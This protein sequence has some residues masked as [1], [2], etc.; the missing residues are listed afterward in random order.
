MIAG[1][2]INVQKHPD[3]PLWLY[4]YSMRAQ[5]HD[6]WNE[7]TCICR[8]LIMDEAQNIVSRPFKKFFNYWQIAPEDI[9]NEPF[10]VTDKMD[11][12]LGISYWYNGI[13][14]IATRGSFNGKQATRAT[15]ILHR[16]YADCCLKMQ[17]QYTY[18]FE[19]IYPANRIIVDYGA[20]EELVLLA[21]ID[22]ETGRELP[23]FANIGFP[24]L[25]TFEGF[26]SFEEVLQLNDNRAEG[27]VV[28]FESGLRVKVKFPEYLRLHR[29]MLG[30]SETKIW[31][32][33][34]NKHGI[35]KL[36]EKA[37]EEY[38]PWI[39]TT[40]AK[41]T[42]SYNVLYQKIM[43]E[44]HALPDFSSQKEAAEYI[45]NSPNETLLF[46]LLHKKPID[47]LVWQRIK[48]DENAS[49]FSIRG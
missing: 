12:S 20:R 29:I 18:L 9:P 19:I 39:R 35:E 22:T 7:A 15:Q 10:V 44:F 47:K 4:N 43:D 32:Y 3:F 49:W 21:V 2:F 6:V 13:W 37:G 45:K 33:L 30:L 36:C 24:I 11:G 38:S 14:S 23:D 1:R 46:C 5:S 28:R 16:K 34:A 8:G 26:N 41:L 25:K 42:S 31:R 40:A 48:P 27:V 17:P